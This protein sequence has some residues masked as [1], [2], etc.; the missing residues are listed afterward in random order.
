MMI[1]KANYSKE[2]GEM[3]IDLRR[4]FLKKLDDRDLSQEKNLR[5]LLVHAKNMSKEL[6]EYKRKVD[7]SEGIVKELQQTG[8]ESVD[9]LLGMLKRYKRRQRD[10]QDEIVKLGDLILLKD[11]EIVAVTEDV[12]ALKDFK[13][14][15]TEQGKQRVLNANKMIEE[16]TAVIKRQ[17]KLI[18]DLHQKNQVCQ[19]KIL[20][21]QEERTRKQKET[22]ALETKLVE[23]E[24]RRRLMRESISV[25]ENRLHILKDH[26]IKKEEQRKIQMDEAYRKAKEL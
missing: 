15:L 17:D 1:A 8:N 10:T 14:D 3:K 2:F 11:S 24:D 18:V 22:N 25:S 23:I 19:Y 5:D 7:F 20:E 16:N 6:E 21:T 9:S 13:A 26:F 12:K 4:E